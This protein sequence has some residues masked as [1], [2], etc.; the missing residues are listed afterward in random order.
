VKELVGTK[1]DAEGVVEKEETESLTT[2]VQIPSLET[3]GSRNHSSSNLV[4]EKIRKEKKRECEVEVES[5][6]GLKRT[7]CTF[8]IFRV[9]FISY[10]NVFP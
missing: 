4:L 1:Y 9:S 8:R 7:N 3:S 6:D 2:A 5:L 10:I